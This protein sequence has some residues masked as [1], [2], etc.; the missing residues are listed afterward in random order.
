MRVHIPVAT[1]VTLHDT[2]KGKKTKI[3]DGTET[4]NAHKTGVLQA[5]VILKSEDVARS[6]LELPTF[7]L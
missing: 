5:S 4:K 3:R 2:W 1:V 7:G 6:R